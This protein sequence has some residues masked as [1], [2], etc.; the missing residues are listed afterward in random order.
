VATVNY[1]ASFD[2]FSSVHLGSDITGDKLKDGHFS[3]CFSLAKG[4]Q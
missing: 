2:F 1:L 3:L 4:V